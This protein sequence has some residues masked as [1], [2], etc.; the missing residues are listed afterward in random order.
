[1]HDAVLQMPAD[2]PMAHLG[3]P[4]RALRPIEEAWR[5][6]PLRRRRRRAGALRRGVPVD[7]R[8]VDI[9]GRRL[10]GA[11]GPH[12]GQSPFL[13]LAE[14]GGAPEAPN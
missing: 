12:A 7:P 4:V 9:D 2:R 3:G 8:V 13:A 11:L 10:I 6:V 5:A 1:M 14:A